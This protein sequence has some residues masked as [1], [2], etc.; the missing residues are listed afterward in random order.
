MKL[1]TVRKTEPPGIT[2]SVVTGNFCSGRKRRRNGIILSL[3][4]R[5]TNQQNK[6][7]GTTTF[8]Y[9]VEKLGIPK[10]DF[11]ALLYR[12]IRT[13][14]RKGEEIRRS[15][16]SRNLELIGFLVIFRL[17]L[18]IVCIVLIRLSVFLYNCN[19]SCLPPI[20]VSKSRICSLNN[21]SFLS[22]CELIKY[23]FLCNSVPCVVV[24]AYSIKIC[25]FLIS[26]FIDHL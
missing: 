2:G 10:E 19:L 23:V 16:N 12:K 6:D 9:G 15:Y 26:K 21:I 1:S 18:K 24:H 22:K 4:S 5:V 13:S 7:S 3:G 25:G 11:Q 20:Y 8:K 14:I 17:H